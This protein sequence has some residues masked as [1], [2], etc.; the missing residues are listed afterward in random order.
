[1]DLERH[2]GITLLSKILYWAQLILLITVILLI[3]ITPSR[4]VSSAGMFIGMLAWICIPL[5]RKIAEV[6]ISAALGPEHGKRLAR[7]MFMNQGGLYFDMFKYAYMDDQALSRKITIEGREHLEGALA[8]GRGI[9]IVSG[10]MNWEVL[11][12][13]ARMVGITGSVMADYIKNPAMQTISKELRSRYRFTVL[14]PKGG[15]VKMLT[16]E[17]AHSRIIGMVIDQRGKRENNLFCDVFGMP[18]PTSPAPALIALKGD[19]LILPVYAVKQKG[20]YTFRFEKPLDARSFGNDFRM[21]DD[22]SDGWK[23]TSVR[24]LSQAIQSWLC[25]VIRENPDQ[26]FWLHCRWARRSDMAKI[27][28]KGIDLKEFV[29]L[30]AD[31]YHQKNTVI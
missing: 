26:W 29:H 8:S 13:F 23:S 21:I 15:M 27:V 3:R 10:H 17:L 6:Q 30:Q 9:M 7:K 12:N 14:P 19:A 2:E 4:I 24:E 31:D 25:S 11:A 20:R 28:R 22:L 18:A 16:D 1:V 5:H